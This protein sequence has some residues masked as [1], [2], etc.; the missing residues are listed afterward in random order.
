M[1]ERDEDEAFW[2]GINESAACVTFFGNVTFFF[3]GLWI[4]YHAAAPWGVNRAQVIGT[5]GH[6]SPGEMSESRPGSCVL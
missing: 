2:F 1:E 6:S 3:K 4:K 5:H